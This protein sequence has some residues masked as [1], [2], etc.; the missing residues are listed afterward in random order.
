MSS[1]GLILAVLCLGIF[2][3]ALDQ[4]VIYGALPDMMTDIRLSVT[5]LDKAAW[6][7]IGYLLGYTFAMPLM[8]RVS[9]VYGHG[10]IYVLSMATFMAG[11]RPSARFAAA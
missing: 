4:T 10:R 11:S 2:V 7:V 9:D 6:I 5:D 1:P 8:G 3:A